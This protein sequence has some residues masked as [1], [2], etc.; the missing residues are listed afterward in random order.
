MSNLLPILVIIGFGLVLSL[1]IRRGV[2][3]QKRADLVA[4]AR[5][6]TA[7]ESDIAAQ[8]LRTMRSRNLAAMGMAIL[9]GALAL[10]LNQ[11]FP[12]ANGIHL[13][14]LP[15]G[16]WV[17]VVLLL[18]FWPIPHDL[19][20]ANENNDSRVSAD[21]TPRSTRMFG[22]VWAVLAPTALLVASLAGL[23][24]SGIAS[25][26]DER[27]RYRELPFQ[28]LSG[29]QV[30]ANMTVTESLAIEGTTGPFPGWYY[31]VPLMTLLVIGA[32]LTLWALNINVRRPSLRSASLQEFDRAVRTHNGYILSTGF[33]AA[34]CFQLLPPVLMAAGAIYNSGY[35]AVYVVG[36]TYAGENAPQMATDPWHL[37]LALCL[38]ALGI[39][40]LIIGVLLLGQL[41]GWIGASVKAAETKV[42]QEG[43]AS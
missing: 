11:A 4:L 16:A 17:L 40:A 3:A 27:G 35:N 36:E 37:A 2:F 33:T 32:L 43:S 9:G 24:I 18:I 12:K 14:L 21:L 22:P 34:L 10:F 41:A 25:S 1:L 7:E 26:P 38:A 19:R 8:I 15:V 6:G 5:Q 28:A 23:V 39:L 13:V 30:D 31:G 29:A 42:R 20:V